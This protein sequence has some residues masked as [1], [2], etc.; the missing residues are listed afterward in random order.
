M[1]KLHTFKPSLITMKIFPEYDDV[2]VINKGK[3][4][5]WA[6]SAYIIFQDVELWYNNRHAFVKHGSRFFDSEHLKGVSDWRDLPATE[7]G[8]IASRTSIIS[9]KKRW[10]YNPRQFDTTWKKIEESARKV[11]R[12]EQTSI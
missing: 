2:S 6:Y 5:I 7:G 4:F 1:K 9:F 12:H 10:A 8:G 3:C 11:L